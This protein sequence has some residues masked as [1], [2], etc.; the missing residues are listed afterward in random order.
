MQQ[1]SQTIEQSIHRA[2]QQQVQMIDVVSGKK[3]V[4][5]QMMQQCT[6]ICALQNEIL[7]LKAR[8]W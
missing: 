6:Q 5:L 7:E 1:T 4:K 3:E 8:F 2:N